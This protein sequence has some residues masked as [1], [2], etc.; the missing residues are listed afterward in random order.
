[1]F[2]APST[3]N[4]ADYTTWLYT[5]AG[6]PEEVLPADS[7]WIPITFDMAKHQINW[8]LSYAAGNLFP[9][10]FYNLAGDRLINFAQDIAGQEFFAGQRAKYR[11][12]EPAVGVVSSGGD[13]G[14][15]MGLVN[16]EQLKQMTWTELQ[17]LKT[18]FGRYYMG[19]AMA[20]GP[21]LFGMS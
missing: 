3:P 7:V 6:I 12:H 17:M 10:V 16:P 2:V 9:L 20:S 4:L 13:G 19:Y 21:T 14:T 18:P 1:M 5:Q 8:E 11:I 15:S